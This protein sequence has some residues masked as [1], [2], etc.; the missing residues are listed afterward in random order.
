ML[1]CPYVCED[2]W[3]SFVIDHPDSLYT[4][5]STYGVDVKV[6]VK[7]YLTIPTPKTNNHT[8]PKTNVETLT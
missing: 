7:N 6:K 1:R 2:K 4:R 5:T 3:A 8:S